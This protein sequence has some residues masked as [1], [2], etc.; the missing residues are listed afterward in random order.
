METAS[1]PPF[2]AAVV[3]AGGCFIFTPTWLIIRDAYVDMYFECCNL[4]A[5][6][7]LTERLWPVTPRY[8]A[9]KRIVSRVLL[10][11]QHSRSTV[12]K[13]KARERSIETQPP[14][15]LFLFLSSLSLS[16]SLSSHKISPRFPLSLS[17]DSKNQQKIM[18]FYENGNF[19]LHVWVW[20]FVFF[21]F[22]RTRALVCSLNPDEKQ[23]N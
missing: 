15:S 10:D 14:L 19:W 21:F 17:R 3:V 11:L 6:E 18:P 20:V 22:F 1:R 23:R 5:R 4:Q 9:R 2:K 13:L 12:R 8:R 7:R 16:L